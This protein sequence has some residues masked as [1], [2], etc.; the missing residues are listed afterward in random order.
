MVDLRSLDFNMLLTLDALYEER[1]VTRAAKRLSVT[2]PTVS[3][4]LLRLRD[5][6]RDPLFVRGRGAMLPT[7]RADELARSIKRV[8]SDAETLLKQEAFDPATAEFTAR[9][10]ANDYSLKVIIVPLLRRLRRDARN[11]R[12]A[13]LPFEIAE[14]SR[15]LAD[16]EIDLALTVPEMAPPDYPSRFLFSDRYV[17]VVGNQHPIR[18]TAISL[19]D[20]CL[21]EHVLVSPT[22]GSFEGVVDKA[23]SE[24]GRRRQVRLS[25]PSFQIVPKI[26]EVE[27]LIAVVPERVIGDGDGRIRK[28]TLP[29]PL[30]GADAIIVWHPRLQDD[31]G[32]SWLRDQIWTACR[33]VE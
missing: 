32:F 10:C 28:L 4:T 18:G 23:L 6:F 1:S 30:Q 2:Q 8:L 11:I 7:P 25:V 24:I 9:I 13:I 3:G 5:V 21:Q 26:L 31:A 27:D 33:A 14:L 12:L 15:K 17:A 19:D 22:G 29:F 20:F 16:R